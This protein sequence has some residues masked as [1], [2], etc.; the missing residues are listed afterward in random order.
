[1]AA[2]GLKHIVGEE[3]ILPGTYA[4]SYDIEGNAE[5]LSVIIWM[6]T[7]AWEVLTLCLALWIAVKQFRNLRRLRSSAGSTVVDMFTVLVRSH[8]LYFASFLA[9][10]CL[11][12]GRN[13]PHILGST[14]MEAAIYN[15]ALQFFL[16]VQMFVL[17]PRLILSVREYNARLVDDSDAST[18]MTSIAFQ[19]HIHVSTSS[20]V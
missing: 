3:A 19:E 1:M 7:T 14:T 13:S 5:F 20:T 15:G 2:I 12:V 17:G 11:Q 16:N 9:V 8:V 4:C 6:L 18:H 10:A